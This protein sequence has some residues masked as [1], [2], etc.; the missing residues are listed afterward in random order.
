[1]PAP[2]P[3]RTQYAPPPAWSGAPVGGPAVGF[4]AA[5]TPNAG[6]PAPNPPNATSTRSAKTVTVPGR[7]SSIATPGAVQLCPQAQRGSVTINNGG[8]APIWVG[9][10]SGVV[11]RTGVRIAMGEDVTLSTTSALWC[12]CGYGGAVVTVTEDV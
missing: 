6:P 7:T 12:N 1:M 8:P 11:E 9:T 2:G 3:A 5:P 4:G 10:D